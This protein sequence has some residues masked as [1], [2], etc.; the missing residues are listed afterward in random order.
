M[1]HVVSPFHRQRDFELTRH[2]FEWIPIFPCFTASNVAFKK[3][4]TTA[5]I[6]LGSSPSSPKMTLSNAYSSSGI[7]LGCKIFNPSIHTHFI[8]KGLTASTSLQFAAMASAYVASPKWFEAFMASGA[9]LPFPTDMPE[10]PGAQK[11][12]ETDKQFDKR[13]SMWEMSLLALDPMVGADPSRWFGHCMLEQMW[14]ARP[15]EM[16]GKYAC[17]IPAGFKHWTSEG[18][19]KNEARSTLFKGILFISFS[20]VVSSISPRVGLH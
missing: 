3:K 16:D 11:E 7:K 2:S 6:T 1:C 19:N 14:G 15:D 8:T 13:V 10:A 17:E 5:A 20:Q 12:G 4:Y 9:P 18:W